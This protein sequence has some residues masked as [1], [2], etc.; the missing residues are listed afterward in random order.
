VSTGAEGGA[1]PLTLQLIL[2]AALLTPAAMD[3]RPLRERADQLPVD[4]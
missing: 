3:P 1:L 2:A 4:R